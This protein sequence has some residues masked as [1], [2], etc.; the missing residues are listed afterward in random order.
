MSVMKLK[1]QNAN[2]CCKKILF[3][4]VLWYNYIG[5]KM[6]KRILILSGVIALIDQVIKIVLTNLLIT[7][8]SVAVI[9]NFFYLTYV[10]NTGAAWGIFSGGRWFLILMSIFAIYAIV[11]YFLLDANITKIEFAGYGLILGGVIGNLIDRVF[12]GYVIDYADFRFDSYLF[13]VFNLADSAIVIGVSLIIFHLISN[14]IKQ[15]GKK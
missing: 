6:K 7:K 1:T 8:D 5:D 12:L 3:S 15:R 10:E 4:F 14:A 9:N 11:K 2:L 13:P